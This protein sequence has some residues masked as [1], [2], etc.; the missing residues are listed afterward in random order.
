M[1]CRLRQRRSWRL[2][3][4]GRE[5]AKNHRSRARVARRR[6]RELRKR[7]QHRAQLSGEMRR[8]AES[9]GDPVAFVW[10][11]DDPKCTIGM[12]R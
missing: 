4:R 3:G 8:R 6:K 10:M 5:M 1:I 11:C 7:H 12:H 2:R 9:V